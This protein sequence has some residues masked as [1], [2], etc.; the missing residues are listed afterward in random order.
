MR[1]DISLHSDTI[2][3]G[4]KNLNSDSWSSFRHKTHFLPHCKCERPVNGNKESE[5]LQAP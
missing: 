2:A 4:K 3:A 1:D 5:S